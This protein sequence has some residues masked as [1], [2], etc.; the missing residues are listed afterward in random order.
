[1]TVSFFLQMLLN[2]LQLASVYILIALGFTLIFGILEIVNMAHGSIY[3]LGGYA[4]WILFARLKVNYFLSLILTIVIIGFIGVAIERIIFRRL[5]GLVMPTIIVSIGLMQVLEQSVLIGFGVSDKSVPNPFPGVLHFWG[6]FFPTQR[7]AVMVIGIGL[8]A[9]LVWWIKK[10]RIGLAFRAVALDSEAASLYGISFN[11]YGSLAFA[12]G[13]GLAGAAG[14]LVAPLFYISPHMGNAPLLKIFIII[15][16]GGL[17]SVPGTILA[18]V[19]LGFIDSF[20][21]TLFDSV[22]AAMVGFAMIIV[23][24]VFKPTGFLGHE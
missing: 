4:V 14:A 19:L 3:M 21:A 1:M 11:R 20:V 2:G 23:V 9:M 6:A 15:I 22:I 24:L 12:I 17:G 8:T 13:C 5:K 10:T 18:G 7:L 16:V